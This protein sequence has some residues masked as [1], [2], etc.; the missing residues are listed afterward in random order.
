[1][2]ALACGNILY[3]TSHIL[4]HY[5]IGQHVTAA[6]ALFAAVALLYRYILQLFMSGEARVGSL[7]F[8]IVADT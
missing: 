7:S 4:H 5:H 8:W 1:M 6:L 3:S 2:I